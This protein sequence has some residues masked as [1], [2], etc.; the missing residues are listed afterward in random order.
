MARPEAPRPGRENDS[1]VVNAER[2]SAIVTARTPKVSANI[3]AGLL[4]ETPEEYQR[5]GD[6]AAAVW[7]DIVRQATGKDRR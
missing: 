1:T 5:R 4:P 3:P 2:K 6:A 7:R